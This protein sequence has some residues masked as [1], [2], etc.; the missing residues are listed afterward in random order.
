MK[1][2]RRSRQKSSSSS[3]VDVDTHPRL[4]HREHGLAPLLVGDAD[5]G[6]VGD[7]RVLE[8]H[9]VDLGRVDVHAAGD[10]QVGRAVGEEQEP[11]LVDAADV[12]EREVVAAIG[13]VGLVRVAEVLEAGGARRP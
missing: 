10:D 2:A 5:H 3:G 8:Q 9:G 1:W 13:A 7:G 12:A 6:H 4:D 11:V